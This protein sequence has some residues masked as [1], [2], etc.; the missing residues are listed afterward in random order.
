MDKKERK[1]RILAAYQEVAK[2]EVHK[3]Y[4]ERLKFFYGLKGQ[5][6]AARLK[7]AVTYLIDNPGCNFGEVYGGA[8]GLLNKDGKKYPNIII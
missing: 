1:L 2:S 5:T 6:I 8:M 7:K 4:A 3:E